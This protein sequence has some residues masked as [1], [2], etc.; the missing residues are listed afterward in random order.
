MV[1]RFWNALSPIPRPRWLLLG[2]A[3]KLQRNENFLDPRGYRCIT[4]VAD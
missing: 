2:F 1:G 3:C 4:G